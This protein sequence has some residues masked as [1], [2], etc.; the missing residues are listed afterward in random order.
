MQPF[1]QGRAEEPGRAADKATAQI[2]TEP[3]RILPPQATPE[4]AD[5]EAGT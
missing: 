3:A 1:I 4:Q 2:A 5:P